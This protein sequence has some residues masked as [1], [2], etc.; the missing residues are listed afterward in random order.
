MIKAID[1]WGDSYI[2]PKYFL[3]TTDIMAVMYP[4]KLEDITVKRVDITS[5]PSIIRTYFTILC[6][7]QELGFVTSSQIVKLGSHIEHIFLYRK[8]GEDITMAFTI[9][10]A[11]YKILRGNYINGASRS[12]I[13]ETCKLLFN[14]G[15]KV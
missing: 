3:N 11:V 8:W 2:L 7:D 13:E 6:Q 10:H 9:F 1:K 12:T 14:I 4:I 5:G 15:L